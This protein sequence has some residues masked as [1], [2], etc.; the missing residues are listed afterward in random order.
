MLGFTKEGQAYLKA[1]EI[2]KG[3][4]FLDIANVKYLLV[5]TEAISSPWKTAMHSA[6]SLSRPGIS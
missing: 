1:E 5:E 6:V 3:N 4:A 2:D